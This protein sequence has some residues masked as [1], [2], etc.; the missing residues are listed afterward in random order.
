MTW[1]FLI[2]PG[3]LLIALSFAAGGWAYDHFHKGPDA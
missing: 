2:G 3:L 1:W